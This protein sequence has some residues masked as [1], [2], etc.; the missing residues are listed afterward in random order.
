MSLTWL[1][2]LVKKIVATASVR[3]TR[4]RVIEAGLA[5][6]VDLRV[7]ER[8]RAAEQPADQVEQRV[9]PRLAERLARPYRP[10]RV[11]VEPGATPLRRVHRR[12]ERA[13]EAFADEQFHRLDLA[14]RE[15]ARPQR[16]LHAEVGAERGLAR[17]VLAVDGRERA[18]RA[19]HRFERGENGG[20]ERCLVAGSEPCHAYDSPDRRDGAIMPQRSDS[21]SARAPQNRTA[22]PGVPPNASSDTTSGA[23]SS[24]RHAAGPR[25]PANGKAGGSVREPGGANGGTGRRSGP[26]GREIAERVVQHPRRSRCPPPARR[27]WYERLPAWLMRRWVRPEVLPE[28]PDTLIDP[29]RPV[30]Y[31]LEVGGLA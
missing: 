25:D 19:A 8:P 15:R 29:G 26:V 7:G 18:V 1:V 24:E 5:G 10:L 20:C 31:L 4:F 30:L 13:A 12:A 23:R 22:S 6:G 14:R 16:R 3:S 9:E 2:T 11:A 17:G 28:R 27:R 21:Q